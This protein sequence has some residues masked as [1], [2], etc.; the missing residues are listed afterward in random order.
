LELKKNQEAL[1]TKIKDHDEAFKKSQ[2]K[3]NEQDQKI[4]EL[5]WQVNLGDREK[6]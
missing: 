4:V 2:R 6:T 5:E 1:N 3:L